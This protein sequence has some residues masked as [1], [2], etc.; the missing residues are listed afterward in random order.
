MNSPVCRFCRQKGVFIKIMTNDIQ[1]ISD[2]S[3]FKGTTQT[4]PQNGKREFDNPADVHKVG[5]TTV[6]CYFKEDSNASLEKMLTD[7]ICN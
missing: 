4:Q 3:D 2:F 1:K 5:E 7:L 6:K